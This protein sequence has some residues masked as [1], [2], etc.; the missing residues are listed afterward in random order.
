MTVLESRTE[1]TA[2]SSD[3]FRTRSLFNQ[4]RF[5]PDASRAILVRAF[6]GSNCMHALIFRSAEA[7]YFRRLEGD[8]GMCRQ[9]VRAVFLPKGLARL[10]WG[11]V[12]YLPK[13]AR[14]TG[15]RECLLLFS[16]G[17]MGGRYMV[18]LH[19]YFVDYQTWFTAQQ[20]VVQPLMKTSADW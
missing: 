14:P 15:L 11:S 5:S 4:Q 9:N 13:P 20:R 8:L 2:L 1:E 6:E 18:F 12:F 3:F 10:G 7:H 16:L 19:L 17:E